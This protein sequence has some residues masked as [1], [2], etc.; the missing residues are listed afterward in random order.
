MTL[1]WT[2]STGVNWVWF[3]NDW[4]LLIALIFYIGPMIHYGEDDYI[5][6]LA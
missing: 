3:A 4:F 1:S 2:D 6:I 5:L